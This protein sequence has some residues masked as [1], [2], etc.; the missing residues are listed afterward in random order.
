M[1][2]PMSVPTFGGNISFITF[3]DDFTRYTNVYLVTSKTESINALKKYQ[4]CATTTHKGK[5]KKVHCDLG[6]RILQ[7]GLEGRCDR[8]GITLTS[9]PRN[10]PATKTHYPKLPTE[11]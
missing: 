11:S 1:C 6:F 8:L 9:A 4:A 7:Q 3:T 10:S 5:I 2:G